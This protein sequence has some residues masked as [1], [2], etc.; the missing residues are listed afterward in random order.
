M[1]VTNVQFPDTFFVCY[2]ASRERLEELH[3]DMEKFYSGR[4]EDVSLRILSPG[5]I[6]VSFFLLF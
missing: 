2:E 1:I 3:T 6:L 5:N 4:V